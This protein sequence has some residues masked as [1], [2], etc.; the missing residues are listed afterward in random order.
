MHNVLG[1]KFASADYFYRV[2]SI[3]GSTG[4]LAG[5]ASFCAGLALAGAVLKIDW[6]R[7]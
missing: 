6:G 4:A 3:W 5:N 7:G 2:V 1:I